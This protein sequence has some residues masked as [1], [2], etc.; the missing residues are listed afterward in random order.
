MNEGG[1]RERK[2]RGVW[3]DTRN[4]LVRG[5]LLVTIESIMSKGH[6]P[7]KM[8]FFSKRVAFI[9]FAHFVTVFSLPEPFV[10]V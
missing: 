7:I 8:F 10:R 1:E 6:E 9:R 4:F 3:R 2:R 5:M